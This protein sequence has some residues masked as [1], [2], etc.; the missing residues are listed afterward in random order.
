V[1]R[2]HSSGAATGE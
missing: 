2:C 1:A